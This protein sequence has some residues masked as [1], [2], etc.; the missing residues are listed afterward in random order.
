MFNDTT[1]CARERDFSDQVNDT[2]VGGMVTVSR[3]F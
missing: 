2:V 3:R 1:F